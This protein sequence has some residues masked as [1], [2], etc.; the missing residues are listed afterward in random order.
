MFKVLKT[1]TLSK[2]GV[3]VSNDGTAMIVPLHSSS[4]IPKDSEYKVVLL[5]FLLYWRHCLINKNAAS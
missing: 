5:Q 3:R 2:Y 1:K 4:P